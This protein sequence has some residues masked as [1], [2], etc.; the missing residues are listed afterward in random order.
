GEAHQRISV[1]EAVELAVD[2]AVTK[3]GI[4]GIRFRDAGNAGGFFRELQPEAFR[5]WRLRYKPVV[6]RLLRFKRDDGQVALGLG[7]LEASDEAVR[8]RKTR[9]VWILAPRCA[10][11]KPR[12]P[13]APAA[14]CP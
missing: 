2:P 12:S 5:I 9:R 7:H 1:V 6:P 8:I 14:P 4:N 10:P 13:R 3:R 11:S